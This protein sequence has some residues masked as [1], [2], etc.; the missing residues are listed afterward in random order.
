[1]TSLFF[2]VPLAISF[3]I[4]VFFIPFWITKAHQIKLVWKDMN[5][6]HETFVAG[7]GGITTITAFL[8]GTLVYLAFLTFYANSEEY[9]AEILAALVSVLFLTGIGIVD[10]LL[11][12]QR[13][14]L[15]KRS[16]ILLCFVAAIPLMAI[17][18]GKSIIGIPILGS[19][20]LGLIYP[21]LLVPIALIGTA[22]TFN[23]LAGFN[24]LEAGQGILLIGGLS[25]VA[26]L[27]GNSWLSILGLCLVVALL[28][29]LLYNWSPAK[30]FPGDCLTY[31]VGGM[32]AI[33][34]ILG[35]FEKIALFFFIPTIIEV[36]LKS[37]GKLAKQ[38]FG[39]PNKDG[40]LSPK[41]P[42]IYSLN[43]AAIYGLE[44]LGVK[45]TEKKV[46]LSI[47]LFQFFFIIAGLII[48]RAGLFIQ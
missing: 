7:S 19:I 29:F 17:N 8:I 10:D 40:S 28:G 23:F 16:R 22:T 11:G 6:Y 3:L 37:R 42:N 32:V 34:A 4:A 1:M 20:D 33:M 31:P 25:I 14:G 27:T 24:G 15:S 12:W 44:K 35:N 39:I 48:F 5:K 43:H 38:S 13:G 47:W 41:Y 9:L 18:A 46:V 45:P 36:I 2:L 30:V 21:L 26:F